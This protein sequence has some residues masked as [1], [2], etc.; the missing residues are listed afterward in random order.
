MGIQAAKWWKIA[1]HVLQ[2]QQ[3]DFI[4]LFYVK[5]LKWTILRLE[6]VD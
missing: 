2:L 4:N 6:F 1:L 3:K 5:T